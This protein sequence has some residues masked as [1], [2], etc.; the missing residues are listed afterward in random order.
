MIAGVLATITRKYFTLI[1]L[2]CVAGEES[3]VAQIINDFFLVVGSEVNGFDRN[4]IY[5]TSLERH[6]LLLRCLLNILSASAVI[7]T[8]LYIPCHCCLF[9]CF[10]FVTIFCFFILIFLNFDGAQW[11]RSALCNWT[12]MKLM[13]LTVL[14]SIIS[15]MLIDTNFIALIMPH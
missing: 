3:A 9:F 2:D 4:G 14:S 1:R 15:Q 6:L 7:L 12:V 8:L 10:N 5:I 11:S 13:N